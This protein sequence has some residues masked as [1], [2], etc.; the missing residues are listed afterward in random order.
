MSDTPA[1]TFW[2]KCVLL[3]ARLGVTGGRLWL[4]VAWIV[5]WLDSHALQLLYAEL[6]A[7]GGD[8]LTPQWLHQAQQLHWQA[9]ASVP[10]HRRVLLCLSYVAL[11][12][13]AGFALEMALGERVALSVMRQ[14]DCYER[15]EAALLLWQ[16]N[17]RVVY[18]KQRPLLFQA[19]WRSERWDDCIIH[20]YGRVQLKTH[21]YNVLVALLVN[22]AKDEL[23]LLR[24]EALKRGVT[25]TLAHH[26][27][28]WRVRFSRDEV[29]A[30]NAFVKALGA[31]CDSF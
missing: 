11:H 27:L 18:P 13:G 20:F 31:T 6:V 22:A 14:G 25:A 1:D 19:L 24:R 12:Q 17:T 29:S 23:V 3:R 15:V 7:K 2:L 16:A 26:L 4:G 10:T 8:A 30:G 9:L 5:L 28:L 21:L